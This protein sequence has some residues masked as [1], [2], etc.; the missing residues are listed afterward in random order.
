[1]TAPLFT[2][3]G[4]DGASLA[5]YEATNGTAV[6]I[7][8]EDASRPTHGVKLDPVQMYE[9]G[10]WLR[11]KAVTMAMA[12]A[13]LAGADFEQSM[14]VS[15]NRFLSKTE[16]PA[17]LVADIT[18]PALETQVEKPR[19]I[20]TLSPEEIERIATRTHTEPLTSYPL[21]PHQLEMLMKDLYQDAA[22]GPDILALHPKQYEA[23]KRDPETLAAYEAWKAEQGPPICPPGEH[24]FACICG[25]P[26]DRHNAPHSVSEVGCP[27]CQRTVAEIEQIQALPYGETETVSVGIILPDTEISFA[28]EVFGRVFNRQVG[29]AELSLPITVTADRFPSG[30][31]SV[32]DTNHG[33][34]TDIT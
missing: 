3:E 21:S 6:V 16:I 14:S 25:L 28:W 8:T 34:W 32:S 31:V 2:I 5:V 18:R 27:V 20:F 4:Q 33:S 15:L 13:R 7:T 1:M 10:L 26:V 22:R 30:H 9:L 23:L 24:E 17:G 11:R 19:D 29:T 12:N